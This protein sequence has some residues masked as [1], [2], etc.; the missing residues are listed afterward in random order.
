MLRQQQG[1]TLLEVLIALSIITIGALGVF[2]LMVRTVDNTER[3]RDTIISVNLAREGIEL[4]RSIRD[5]DTLGFDDLT[6]GDWIIDSSAYYNLNNAAS[7]PNISTCLNCLLYIT[8]GRYT[9]DNG[10]DSTGIR[11]MVSIA[12]GNTIACET[13]A[14][15]EKVITVE[16][17]QPGSSRPYSLVTHLTDWR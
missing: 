7:S 3:N 17:L 16:V 14:V 5:S 12:D 6:T 10:G 4:V 1:F 8:N 9:H 13:A 11:R 2:A 15:C